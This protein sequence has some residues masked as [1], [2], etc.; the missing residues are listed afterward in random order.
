MRSTSASRALTVAAAGELED[1]AFPGH[2]DEYPGL[3]MKKKTVDI[4]DCPDVPANITIGFE[5]GVL[6]PL[7]APKHN[8]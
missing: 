7:L 8:R 4:E 1:P 2:T 3:V 5:K 6:N